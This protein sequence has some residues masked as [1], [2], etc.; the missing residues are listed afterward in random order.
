MK[1]TIS[2]I[3]IYFSLLLPGFSQQT[4]DMK[5]VFLAAESYY[6]F[7]EFDEALPLYLRMHRTYPDNYNVYY[8]IGVCYLNNAYEK[9]K[10]VFY[11]EKAAKNIN[12]RRTPV[13]S[14]K[15]KGSR[16]EAFKSVGLYPF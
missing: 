5:Q 4:M 7:E 13:S 15:R 6:L 3:I 12:P 9:D 14:F 8:K 1:K 10:S 16:R 11:L 2:L